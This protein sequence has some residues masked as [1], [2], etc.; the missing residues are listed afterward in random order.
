MNENS[1]KGSVQAANLRDGITN[2]LTTYEYNYDR[3]GTLN[4]LTQDLLHEIEWS[5]YDIRRRSKVYEELRDARRERR[6]LMDENSSIEPLYYALKDKKS[7][8]NK[9]SQVM[10]KCRNEEEKMDNRH[11]RPKVNKDREEKLNKMAKVL[12]GGTR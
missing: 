4:E 3:I 2:I 10:G 7:F 9:L 8:A 12:H 5:N 6:R 11:Y 1:L